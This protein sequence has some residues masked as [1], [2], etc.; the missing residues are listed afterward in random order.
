MTAIPKEVLGL[1]V[2]VVRSI[3]RTAGLHIV[4]TDLQVLRDPYLQVSSNDVESC[5]SPDRADHLHPQTQD[6]QWNCSHLKCLLPR[7][8]NL[9][10]T[11]S[12]NALSPNG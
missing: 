5:S 9:S 10:V 4:G 2:E 7:S 8:M 1:R 3:R 6:L 11:A 12:T